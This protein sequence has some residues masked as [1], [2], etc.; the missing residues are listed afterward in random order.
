MS[1][2]D[3]TSFCV[4]SIFESHNGTHWFKPIAGVSTYEGSML[5]FFTL[6]QTICYSGVAVASHRVAYTLTSLSY[7]T[8]VCPD[9]FALY[10]SDFNGLESNN[11]C[12]LVED[13]LKQKSTNLNI[14][15]S[16]P[17]VS[18]ASS[19]QVLNFSH[20]NLH[21]A[22]L[23]MLNPLLCRMHVLTHLDLGYCSIDDD[24]VRLIANLFI[25]MSL[26]F[27]RL[28]HNNITDK[29]FFSLTNKLRYCRTLEWLD[30][31][32]NQLSDESVSFLSASFPLLKRLRNLDLSK[33]TI[34][35]DGIQTLSECIERWRP[36][37]RYESEKQSTKSRKQRW[38]TKSFRKM[39]IHLN[40]IPS[41]GVLAK[42]S[43]LRT[44]SMDQ[45]EE[46]IV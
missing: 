35:D 28:S 41:G 36:M 34:S 18:L 21:S 30:V 20:N 15:S 45:D 23:K 26:L 33:N 43:N 6:N 40:R 46:D 9:L 10:L 13:V 8:Q 2:F 16:S 29:G 19:I 11:V 24:G 4:E 39:S 1:S 22:G 44:K 3:I 32:A 7:F 37:S 17:F 27:I 5:D 25:Q 14:K 38:T 12:Y 31:S 42:R